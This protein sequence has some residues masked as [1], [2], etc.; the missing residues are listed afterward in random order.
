MITFLWILY[1]V[2][3]L[4]TSFVGVR[5]ILLI[6]ALTEL[7]RERNLNITKNKIRILTF[8]LV[9]PALL[10]SIWYFYYLH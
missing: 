3:T 4:Y 7:D 2:L 5:N 6:V 1:L 9:I 10:W 8:S